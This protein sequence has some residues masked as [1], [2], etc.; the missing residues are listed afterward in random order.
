[1]EGL[2]ALLSGLLG[3]ALAGLGSHLE[4]AGRFPAWARGWMLWPLK[5][6][7]PG[8]ARTQG[9]AGMSLGVALPLV[10]LASAARAQAGLAVALAVLAVT[11][12]F[13][14]S[15]WLSYRPGPARERH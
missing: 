13:V 12:L 9:A 10:V 14:Y 1:M 5:R 15:T 7:T 4:A 11:C 3:A 6:L 8:V 2:V